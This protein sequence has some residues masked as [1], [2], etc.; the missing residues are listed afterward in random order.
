[1]EIIEELEPVR[2]GFYTGSVGWMGYNGDVELNIVIR[3]MLAKD[4]LAYVQAGAG[5]V[6][7]SVP[8][9]EYEE[10]LNKARALWV[11]L[12]EAAAHADL[13]R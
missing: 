7:D 5:V 2:R 10:S 6:A 8:E 1:M 12:E 11:A 3:T 13:S 9:K 4:G